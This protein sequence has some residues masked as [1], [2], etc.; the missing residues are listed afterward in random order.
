VR[1]QSAIDWG[2]YAGTGFFATPE[3]ALKSVEAAR[4][5]GHNAIS[6]HRRIGEALVMQQADARGLYL[7]EE[8]GGFRMDDGA[9][10]GQIMEEKCRR[11][12]LRD[13]NHPSLLIYNLCNEDN[14]WNTLRERVMR[15][16]AEMDGTRLVVNSSGLDW[17]AFFNHIRPYESAIRADYTDNHTVESAATFQEPDL[18]SHADVYPGR[19]L[20]W[21]E[22]RCY[23]GPSNWYDV[24]TMLKSRPD[25]RPGYDL[26]VYQPL[27]DQ[28][29]G[30]FATCR[31]GRIGSGNIKTPADVSRQAGR[32]LMYTDGRLGQTI[33][34]NDSA[35]GYAINGWSGGPQA[36]DDWTAWDSAICDEGRNLKGPAADFAYWTRTL[37]VAIQRKNGKYFTPGKTAQFAVHLIDEGKLPAGDYVL[38]LSVTDGAGKRTA[39]AREIPVKVEG[40]DRY[41]QDLG[42]LEVP[43][44]ASW[45]GG[46]ITVRGTLYQGNRAAA[47]GAEQVLLRNRPSFRADLA[48]LTCAVSNWPA[49]ER[50]LSDAGVQPQVFAPGQTDVRC[51]LAGQVPSDLAVLKGMLQ[52][53]RDRGSLLI[54][55]F[56]K[57]W[58]DLLYRGG[59]L[60]QAVTQWGGE[61]TGNWNGNGWG[62]LDHF[63]GAQA[64]PSGKTISTNGWEVPGN[65]TGFYPFAS[66]YRLGAYGLH[67][68]RISPVVVP[69]HVQ[70]DGGRLPS[71][72]LV[73]L[74]TIDYGKGKILL[75]ATYPVDDNNPFSDLLFYNMLSLGC[76]GRW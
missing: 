7:Y 62:Y 13:R 17:G 65:P 48:G 32:G 75:D 74:G 18:G 6:F 68:K 21:G 26:N 5:I 19:V 72:V 36:S 27:Y 69:A 15:M 11:M 9:L 43:L 12:A 34:Q 23:T 70:N 39:F 51:I 24:A 50:A 54:T 37:Q 14:T 40:G 60:S 56:D 46:Y 42:G 73:L 35:S 49:A 38:K 28:I 31:L 44:D 47:D 41:A 22:V 67:L 8:P 25:H 61:Q 20:Y 66:R 58:A 3:M 33:L 57:S 4:A 2:Y 52:Q 76:R 10:A 63:V 16:I 53:V 55:R 29:A 45:R 59:V 71:G 30:I 64:L 1:L